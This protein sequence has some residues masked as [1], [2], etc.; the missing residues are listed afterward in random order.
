MN[1]NVF[2]HNQE[3]TGQMSIIFRSYRKISQI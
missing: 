3:I 2:S 1:Y